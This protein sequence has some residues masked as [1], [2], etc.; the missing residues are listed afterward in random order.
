MKKAIRIADGVLAF[1]CVIIFAFIIYGT[2]A[3]PSDITFY[4]SSDVAY[5]NIYRLDRAEDRSVDYQ[6]DSKVSSQAGE[7]KVFGIIP[8]KQAQVTQAKR[9]AVYVSG[10]SFGIKLYTDG[11]IVVG[12]RDVDLGSSSVNPAKE[13]GIEKGDII[14]QINGEKMLSSDQVEK[15]LNDNNGK[16]YSIVVKR[17]GNYKSFS[18]KPAYSDREGCYKVGLWVRD[19]TAGIGTITFYNPA[20]STVAALGHPITDVDTGEI[21]P[22]LNGEAV[23]ASVTKLYK[24]R[25]GETGSLCCDFSKNV[26]GK[27][28]DNKSC[29]IYGK[30]DCEISKARPYEVAAVQEIEKGDATLLCTLDGNRV[31]EYKVEIARISYRDGNNDKNMV[32]KIKDDRLIKQA[33]GIVQGMSGSPI[34]Q[35]G[36]LVGA[37][38]HVIV[39]NP[40]KGYAIFAQSMLKQSNNVK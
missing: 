27:L 38:T 14:V 25:A 23:R 1:F 8:V 10:E 11:V 40:E 17:A 26:I 16:E 18:L 3:L 13:A 32:I 15:V 20:N 5:N 36:R 28:T 33:G 31:N 12:T 2:Y 9:Q 24:S 21:M 37:L 4:S 6:N 30:Y 7:L 19:S 22:I 39:D 34:I 29:G 35:N